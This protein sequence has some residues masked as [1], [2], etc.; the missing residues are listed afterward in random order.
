MYYERV[1][2]DQLMELNCC[3]PETDDPEELLDDDVGYNTLRL[4]HLRLASASNIT[5]IN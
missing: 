1:D 3:N 2:A 5:V 4:V